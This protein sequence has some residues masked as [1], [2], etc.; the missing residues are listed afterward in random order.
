[1][2]VGRVSSAP[3]REILALELQVSDNTLSE[4]L[5]R[6]TALQLGTGNSPAGAVKAVKEEL[7]R[8]GIALTGA[9]IADCCGLSPGSRLTPRMLFHVMQRLVTHAPAAVL[10]GMPVLTGRN[11]SYP[12]QAAGRVILKSG[13]L[14][15]VVSLSGIILRTNGGFFIYS[16]IIN[17]PEGEWD[18]RSR[19]YTAMHELAGKLVT[20]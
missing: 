20:L 8:Q 1:M 14:D 7:A 5:G 17:V 12:P 19:G 16:V 2:R 13:S 18:A 15:E 3:L 4:E 9:K 10:R 11:P 6:L